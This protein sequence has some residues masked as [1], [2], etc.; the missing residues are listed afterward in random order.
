MKL[1]AK[2]SMYYLLCIIPILVV[3][4]LINYF[5]LASIVKES[6]EDY[7]K[8]RKATIANYLE[9]QDT[10]GLNFFLQNGDANLIPVAKNY[11]AKDTFCDTL[12]FDS[13]END[14]ADVQMLG[15]VIETKKGKF[16][17]HLWR[18]TLDDDE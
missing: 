17:L 1:L 6:N 7:F 9:K 10:T 8:K 11:Y 16:L 5:A 14:L 4:S 13:F 2:T 3:A 15:T 18:S 12:I